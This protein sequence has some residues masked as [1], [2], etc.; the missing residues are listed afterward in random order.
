MIPQRYGR[1]V[2]IASVAG[3]KGSRPEYMRA[4]AYHTSKGGLVNFTRALAAEWGQYGITVN[5]ICPGFIPSKMTQ[6]LLEKITPRV[7]RERRR[8]T[9][10]ASRA[11]SKGSCVLLVE[12]GIAAH[13]GPGHR[14]G[15]GRIGSMNAQLASV[16][17]DPVREAHAF[18]AARAGAVSS[19]PRFQRPRAASS[20]RQFK[21][22]QS[23]PTYLL[24][25]GRGPVSFCAASRPARCCPRRTRS[26]ASSASSARC[27]ARAVPVPKPICYCADES[28]VGTPFYVMEYVPGPHLLG[29]RAR[30]PQ[31]RAERRAV[32]D[33]M[34]RVIAA[35]HSIDPAAVGLADFGQPRRLSSRA[36]S[37]AGPGSTAPRETRAHRGDGSSSSTGLPA[38][39]PDRRAGTASRTATFAS[40]TSSSTRTSCA[41]APSSTGSS[42][43]SATRSRISR[44]TA[45]LGA[46]RT[47]FARVCAGLDLAALGIPAGVTI[48]YAV[49]LRTHRPRARRPALRFLHRVQPVPARLDPAGRRGARAAPATPRAP[50]PSRPDDSPAPSPSSAGHRRKRAA[51]ERRTSRM[52]FEYPEKVLRAARAAR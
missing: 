30:R 25:N 28:V 17:H 42:R 24:D 10:S 16:R 12:R 49:V 41:S 26:T 1:I 48:T 40:T 44:T 22:G 3:L 7:H 21:G 11:T 14:R 19:R 29:A 20:V 5:A 37:S 33:E 8:C 18:D 4:I 50:T 46:C 31:R 9:R 43:R 23:N 51:L 34:N 32:Y 35:I 47:R 27:T 6:G 36:R 39:V 15:R 38:H 45:C 13:H 52:N 2:N